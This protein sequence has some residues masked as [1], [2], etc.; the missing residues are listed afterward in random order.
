MNL[1]SLAR[2]VVEEQRSLQSALERI[3]ADSLSDGADREA[4]R[5]A[6]E[7]LLQ[8]AERQTSPAVVLDLGLLA[9]GAAESLEAVTRGLVPLRVG[10]LLLALEAPDAARP[11]LE[12]A[13]Q[14]PWPDEAALSDVSCQLIRCLTDLREFDRVAELLPKARAKA[15][16]LG[17]RS[18]EVI[19]LVLAS[20]EASHRGA[21][22]RA[23]KL[24][25]T[26][27]ELESGSE[28][29]SLEG[30]FYGAPVEFGLW[31][32]LGTS[33]RDAGQFELAIE[34]FERARETARVEARPEAEFNVAGELAAT[35]ELVGKETESVAALTS[36]ARS[37]R[38]ATEWLARA[39]RLVTKDPPD[40]EAALYLVREARKSIERTGSEKLEMHYYTVLGRVHAAK[41]ELNLARLAFDEALHLACAS[42]RPA[43]ELICRLNLAFVLLDLN[44]LSAAQRQFETALAMGGEL[45]D[46]LESAELRRS[47]TAHLV[48]ASEILALFYS[49]GWRFTADDSQGQ[50]RDPDLLL[51][52][53]QRVKA[54]NLSGWIGLRDRI[55]EKGAD[56]A[57]VAGFRELCGVEAELERAAMS[58][59]A[60][61]RPIFDRQRRARRQL[62][63]RGLPAKL[64]PEPRGHRDL[65]DHLA[66]STVLIDLMS[67]PGE[68][69]FSCLAP[70]GEATCGAVPWP[71]EARLAFVER[72]NDSVEQGQRRPGA[73]PPRSW[74]LGA[75]PLRG[76][77]RAG[78]APSFSSLL[79]ELQASFL[80]PLLDAAGLVDAPKRLLIS[81]HR[82][83]FTLPLGLAGDLLDGAHVSLLPSATCLELLRRRRREGNGPRLKIGDATRTLGLVDRELAWLD[84]FETLEPNLGSIVAGGRRAN[85]LHFAGHG[86]FDDINP[87]DSGLIVGYSLAEGLNEELFVVD[88]YY[89]AHRRLTVTGVLSSVDLPRCDLVTLSACCTGLPR[90]EPASEFL[91]LPAAFF[92]AGARNVV[93]SLWPVHDGATALLMAEFYRCLDCEGVPPSEA[94]HRARVNLQNL[95]RPQAIDRL[96][97]DHW[98][99][100]ED[101]PFASPH[102]TL[103]FQ[104]YGVD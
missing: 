88:P 71:R 63:A 59:I 4:T 24:L 72:W 82:E 75:G 57:A 66:D 99:P 17:E 104:H 30:L 37:E 60:P 41:G 7:Q 53:G 92:V 62:Q 90:I 95:R 76:A 19:L 36:P 84:G 97:S 67:G 49:H 22:S 27:I 11:F 85:V 50:A 98:L 15:R 14:A 46:N 86:V 20:R 16:A 102:Y 21:H 23:V 47:L 81:P 31:I 2:E 89:T 96:G 28:S 65:R 44:R 73:P 26:A 68:V 79:D 51:R 64:R 35:W 1:L 34:A 5:L 80:K 83:L 42:R 55:A 93:A 56:P 58:P 39:Y 29:R 74:R 78:E 45:R 48:K 77:A 69:F 94:L 18:H 103:A 43:R 25:R 61:L 9:E 6:V 12:R 87:Y 101:P 70:S 52:L 32:E 91:S 8:R 54:V 13:E 100:E 10:R 38:S 40:P 3:R 33:A